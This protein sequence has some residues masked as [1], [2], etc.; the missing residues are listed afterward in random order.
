MLSTLIGSQALVLDPGL[1][2]R[3][4]VG[5]R[6]RLPRR[7]AAAHGF[8]LGVAGHAPEA[9]KSTRGAPEMAGNKAIAYIEP[10]KVEV[11]TID[12]PKLERMTRWMYMTGWLAGNAPT[13][14]SFTLVPRIVGK[15]RPSRFS[16]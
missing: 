10:G 2:R 8:L 14:R 1:D 7:Q 13:S 4:H 3:T 16:T 11:Q 15:K 5:R 9:G 6:P 12:Y